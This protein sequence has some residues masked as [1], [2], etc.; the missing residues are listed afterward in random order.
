LLLQG[1]TAFRT[2]GEL[3]L[4]RFRTPTVV[5]DK[6]VVSRCWNRHS[7][8]QTA[9]DR[10]HEDRLFGLGQALVVLLIDEDQEQFPIG[11]HTYRHDRIFGEVTQ[12]QRLELASRNLHCHGGLGSP[13]GPCSNPQGQGTQRQQHPHGVG[14]SINATTH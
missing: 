7:E 12:A 4:L 8:R 2:Q 5:E 11:L 3:Y 1:A 10:P 13:G 6:E 14:P 9:I